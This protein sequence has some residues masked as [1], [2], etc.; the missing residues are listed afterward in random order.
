MKLYTTVEAVPSRMIGLA[1]FLA[2]VEGAGHTKA[3]ALDLLQPESQRQTKDKKPNM[4]NE[5]LSAALELG[6][7]EEYETEKAE[8]ALRLAHGA[9]GWERTP[10]GQEQAVAWFTTRILRD[11]VGAEARNLATLFSWMLTIPVRKTPND[12]ASWKNQFRLDGFDLDAFGLNNDARWANLFDWAR[13]LGLIWQTKTSRE[14]PGVVCDPASLVARLIGDVLPVQGALLAA[15]FRSRIAAQVP[16]LDGGSVFKEVRQRVASARGEPPDAV[17]RWSPAMG[18]ALRE[19][20]DRQVIT[21]HCPDDQR[22]FLLFDDG[23]RM[24]FVSRAK[25]G[26]A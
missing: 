8:T 4:A 25:A 18:M 23:E 20:R 6:L 13:F 7:V 11:L 15:E 21:Y 10:L 5:V 16:I 12:L 2:S 22:T 3:S 19:L 26:A 9:C 17:D 14:A 1:R 24:A